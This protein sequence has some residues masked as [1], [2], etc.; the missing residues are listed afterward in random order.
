[1]LNYKEIKSI[2]EL[3]KIVDADE[4]HCRVPLFHGTRR[5]ALQTSDADRERFSAACRQILSFANKYYYSEKIDWDKLE[6]YKNDSENYYFL[7]TVVHQ[8][9]SSLY[10]YGA[11]YL[12]L[13]YENAIGFAHYIG[14]EVGTWAYAQ[15]KGFEDWG[16]TLDDKTKEAAKI[17]KR[18]YEKYC[19]S[20]KVILVYYGVGF[21]DLRT[22]SGGPFLYKTGDKAT[23]EES[24][25]EDIEYLYKIAKRKYSQLNFRLSNLDSYTAHLLPE[26]MLRDGVV[27]FEE[28]PDVDRFIK[29]HNLYFLEKWSF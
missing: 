13:S 12:T 11:F 18:E 20:E 7:S 17:V 14:G 22:E 6:A 21:E 19:D 1:M 2:Y 16:V 9:N 3:K 29:N 25:R 10:E 15:I 23:D 8:Y 28:E 4:R 24:A 5:Y 26:R 27:L